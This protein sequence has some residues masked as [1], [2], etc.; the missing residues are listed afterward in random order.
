MVVKAIVDSTAEHMVGTEVTVGFGNYLAV[1]IPRRVAGRGPV[2]LDGF[3][4][5]RDLGRC[6]PLAQAGIGGKYLSAREVMN[7]S[8][9]LHAQIVVGGCYVGHVEIGADLLGKGNGALNNRNDVAEVVGFVETAVTGQYLCFD[10]LHQVEIDLYGMGHGSSIMSEWP[11]GGCHGD[12]PTCLP[13]C[14]RWTKGC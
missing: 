5:E 11:A 3:L 1:K 7:G 8:G 12:H 10:E 4:H 9:T 2:V 6:E 14:R 13:T